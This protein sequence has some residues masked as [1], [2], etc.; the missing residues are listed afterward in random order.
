[1][2]HID[3]AAKEKQARNMTDSEL[4]Y[5]RLD[6]RKAAEIWN[7]DPEAD[8]DGNGGYYLDEAS[9]YAREQKRRALGASDG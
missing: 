4:H 2:R 6:A 8:S 9:I 1:M 7:R 3:W 5:A